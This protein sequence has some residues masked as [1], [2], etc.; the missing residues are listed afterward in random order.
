LKTNNTL[1]ILGSLIAVEHDELVKVYQRTTI[2]QQGSGKVKEMSKDPQKEIDSI[3]D[4]VNYCRK[5]RDILESSDCE[6]TEEL[7]EISKL[8]EDLVKRIVQLQRS[9]KTSRTRAN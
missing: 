1:E 7:S 2:P 4:C 8:K 3:E 5:L 6:Y 9:Q